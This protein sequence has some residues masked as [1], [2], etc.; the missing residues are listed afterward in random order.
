LDKNARAGDAT[1]NPE[2]MK[3][4]VNLSRCSLV[5]FCHEATTARSVARKTIMVVFIFSKASRLPVRLRC[6]IRRLW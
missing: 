1:Q 4:Q 5:S 3:S 6:K 2:K